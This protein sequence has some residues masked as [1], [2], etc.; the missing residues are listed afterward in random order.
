MSGDYSRLTFDP[1]RDFAAVLSQQGRVWTDADGNE[2][3]A[4]AL[5]RTQAEALDTIGPTGVPS[6]TP[7][8]FK[9]DA[10]AGNM[11][12]GAGR[13][14]VDGL[15]AENHGADPAKW[16]PRLAE[17]PGNAAIP[18]ES[19]PY[20][21]DQPALPAGAGPH[22]VYLKAWQRE[23]TSIEDPTIVEPALGVDTTTRLQTVWQV[24]VIGDVGAGVN[25]FTPLS[26][27]SKFVDAEPGAGGRLSTGTF[28]VPGATTPCEVPPGGGY[29]GSENQLYRVEI[30]T[31]GKVG[32]GGARFKWSRDN[33]TVAS[34]VTHIHNLTELVVES[35]GKDDE[36]SFSDG[37][38]VEVMDDWRELNGL[39]GEMRRIRPNKGV[40]EETRTITLESALPNGRFPVD[41]QGRTGAGR[42][43]RVRRWD[44]KGR[45]LNESGTLH[46]DLDSTADGTIPVTAGSIQLEHG[47]V[48]KFSQDVADGIL[49]TGD[50]WCFAA[51]TNG[52]IDE[53]DDEPPRGIHAH[54]AR[55][56]LVSFP[57]TETDCRPI[58]DPLSDRHSLSY[59][60]GDTQQALPSVT[61][62]A[63]LT[64]LP[65]ELVVGV[66]NGGRPVAGA[67]V[68]FQA[69]GRL[70]GSG[71]DVTVTTGANGLANMAW[72]LDSTSRI[73]N[74]T[75]TL[76][77]ADGTPRGLPVQFSATLSLADR[78]A[79]KP[80]A[81]AN[82]SGTTTV[83]EALDRLCGT[84]GGGCD[85]IS[86]SPGAGWVEALEGLAVGSDATV[87]FMTGLF[88]TSRPVNLKELR[89]VRLKGAGHGTRIVG[90]GAE[91]VLVFDGCSSVHIANLDVEVESYPP[92]ATTGM[93]GTVTA[94]ECDRVD[95]EHVRLTCP[96]GTNQRATCLTVRNG[97][98]DS[99]A[100][101]VRRS[102]LVRVQDCELVV[103]HGQTGVVVVNSERVT[104]SGSQFL[105][106]D[107]PAALDVSRLLADTARLRKATALLARG[108]VVD[109]KR[110]VTRA[111][112]NTAFPVGDFVV[113]LNSP[114]P[115][116]EWRALVKANRP[117]RDQLANP[118]GV[119]AF[120]EKLVSD[121]TA[122]H[123]LLPSFAR[124]VTGFSGR[125]PNASRFFGTDEG[126]A[127]VRSL[128]ASDVDV[129]QEAEVASI[130][131]SV[132]LGA[133]NGAV[134]FD[135]PLSQQQWTAALRA[136]PTDDESAVGIAKHV[137]DVAI[138]ILRDPGFAQQFAPGFLISLGN[139]NVAS[140][141]C[142]VRVAGTVVGEVAV[143]R[144][145]FTATSE[146]V[147]V[148]A[149]F[150][151]PRGFPLRSVRS[152][153]VAH[154]EI[155][156]SVPFELDEAPRAIFVGNADRILVSDN[157]TT[158]SGKRAVS[159][160]HLEGVFGNHVA[161]KD[162][163]LA[164]CRVG[165][166]MVDHHDPP[167]PALWLIADN[168]GQETG[169]TVEAPSAARVEGNVP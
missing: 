72:E 27:I 78:V 4:V 77:A 96:A 137:K 59:V 40:D 156:L 85:T 70:A 159:G 30:H 100:Q 33:A 54:C 46:F 107:L 131:R 76:L 88:E 79:Y 80:D 9:I 136:F 56:A 99:D 15:L 34:R 42:N 114:V 129:K 94:L 73:Q 164:R 10:V 111:S 49:R 141:A 64:P 133:T 48:V 167:K 67:R 13:M 139:Q 53:L 158:V 103:G 152:V 57:D 148:A 25:C 151:R 154:N 32:V 20:F 102:T 44:Q 112:F 150:R 155:R 153:R 17:L 161:V 130:S 11:T 98:G 140:A 134:R 157:Q 165:I 144:N 120:V 51:R 5:R 108:L 126:R 110:Q 119:A 60:S 160:I 61:N 8:G 145:S 106:P 91:A 24:K 101:T 95:L 146:A 143:E 168:L 166:L 142:G 6:A 123:T 104:V 93:L 81:C 62:P 37:D 87:C 74:A 31:P 97:G 121:T 86:L 68:R 116:E 113:R 89:H 26:A 52:S 127:S 149:S 22:L 117:T 132:N 128:L 65:H 14:Y 118:E 55:L 115:E 90:R 12:I 58:F 47:I 43:T 21:P 2:G 138:R 124:L 41:G 63:A 125:L 39:P 135:S 71:P 83:Q 147:H 18:Y 84:V 162:N 45:V 35:I 109:R 69:Q 75:A 28:E 16:N 23:V 19:Q 29:K 92:N 7:D 1:E 169:S 163:R 105:T 66:A 36:L 38:W 3:T 122:D 82:L 50:W